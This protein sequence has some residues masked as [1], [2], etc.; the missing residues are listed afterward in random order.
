MLNAAAKCTLVWPISCVDGAT[1]LGPVILGT[2]LEGAACYP[3]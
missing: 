1:G 3:A 2:V